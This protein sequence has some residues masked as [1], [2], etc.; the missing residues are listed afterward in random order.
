MDASAGLI[1]VKKLWPFPP[2]IGIE[3]PEFGNPF[4]RSRRDTVQL[5][6]ARE[7]QA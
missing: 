1:L 7:M 5:L 3:M 6:L 2:E 4:P